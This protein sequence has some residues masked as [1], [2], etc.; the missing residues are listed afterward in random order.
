M[1]VTLSA[2]AKGERFGKRR[3]VVM[4]SYTCYSVAASILKAGLDIL[5]CDI[6][7]RS[8][9]YDWD[10]ISTINFD[11]TLA[12]VSSNLYGI[13]NQL[14]RLEELAQEN[15]IAMVDD[16]AQCLGAT[17]DDRP[18]GTFGD[19]G[20]LSFDKGKVVTSINGGVAI[21]ADTDLGER[22][23]GELQNVPRTSARS[24][25]LDLIK[26]QA[27]FLLLRPSLYWIPKSLPFLG[28]GRTQYD[29][30]FPL[31]RYFDSLAPLAIAQLGRLQA[32][33]E[34]RREKAS[35][36]VELLR[37]SKALAT[38]EPAAG[39]EPVYLRFPL[40]V[41]DQSARRRILETCSRLGCSISYP[42]AIPDVN[43]LQGRIS[44][45]NNAC[46]GGRTLA[47]QILTLPTHSSVNSADIHSICR[48]IIQAMSA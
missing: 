18:V 30:E 47:R 19:A 33:T 39:C 43:E 45:H 4:P 8:A 44:V 17:C 1:T 46:E 2:L 28:L 22:L 32:L 29:E 7:P 42:S 12:I 5:V 15:G 20:I 23:A 6:E 27:Y 13:P 48:R 31:E 14:S 21:T 35:L 9:D 40:R 38:I 41:S 34:E 25:V 11:E 3:T 37:E 26:L 36:Y 16:A 24:R 10:Q